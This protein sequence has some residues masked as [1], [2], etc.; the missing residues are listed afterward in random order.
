MVIKSSNEYTKM[1]IIT[2]CVILMFWGI[3]FFSFDFGRIAISVI[4]FLLLALSL[5]SWISSTQT[6]IMDES[7]CS[8][9]LLFVTHRYSWSELNIEMIDYDGMIG[10]RDPYRGG[11]IFYKGKR[12]PKFLKPSSY[13]VFA[14]PLKFFHVNFESEA[15]YNKGVYCP[16]L[17][18]VS[19]DVF[20]KK[21]NE[22]GV[23]IS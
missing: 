2:V 17:Y 9:K 19:K 10:Y 1:F 21:M 20:L 12:R 8:V 13:S 5:A 16:D 14:H 11:V 18:S 15:P 7:G 22:W 3:V 4:S 6:L 23:K